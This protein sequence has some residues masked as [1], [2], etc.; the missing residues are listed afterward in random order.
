MGVEAVINASAIA[1]F[2]VG[3]NMLT[4]VEVIVVTVAA[5]DLEFS[6]KVSAA[7]EV[8]AVV[9]TGATVGGESG[10]G[11]EMNGSGSTAVMVAL[12]FEYSAPLGGTFL[13]CWAL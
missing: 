7:V 5:I 9:W 1:I 6:F 8:L 12:E 4:D 13:N 2:G 11:P 3:I 10:I